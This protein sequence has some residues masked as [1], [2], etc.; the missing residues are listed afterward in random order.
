MPADR[1]SGLPLSAAVRTNLASLG[2]CIAFGAAILA[3]F[4]AALATI[5]LVLAATGASAQTLDMVKAR[6]A[7]LCGVNEGLPGFSYMD[8]RGA[9]SGFD[10]DV[11]R[12]IA[13]ATLGDPNRVRLVPL[14]AEA[15]FQALKDGKIDVLS[16]KS[17]WTMGASPNTGSP[18]PPSPITTARA[19]WR[20]ARCAS[21]PRSNS[22][23]RGFACSA[24]RRRSTISATSSR[25]IT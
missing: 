17:T 22:T 6:G 10:V 23:A 14:T 11:C 16:R 15:R 21:P 20:R 7:V 13:A 9:W 5:A 18:S 8:E 4:R 24:G 1:A 25:P 19:S 3:S 2:M 12:A